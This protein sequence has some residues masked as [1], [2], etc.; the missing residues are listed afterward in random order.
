M[1]LKNKLVV[2]IFTL[3]TTF[4]VV[5]KV[6]GNEG[7]GPSYRDIS[8]PGG[9]SQLFRSHIDVITSSVNRIDLSQ[10]R[11]K[12]SLS[13]LEKEHEKKLGE[14][15]LKRDAASKY[16]LIR[17]NRSDWDDLIS[18]EIEKQADIWGVNS[19]RAYWVQVRQY[20]NE[21]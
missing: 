15:R 19:V 11:M 14:L 10:N 2:V 5:T 4:T 8:A 17:K 13:S 12:Q 20:L 16:T 7:F 21:L 18:I 9:F 6:M 3:I 1:Y